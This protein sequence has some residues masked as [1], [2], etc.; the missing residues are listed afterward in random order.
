MLCHA[1]DTQR[2]LYSEVYQVNLY[3]FILSPYHLEHHRILKIDKHAIIVT[4]PPRG[5]VWSCAKIIDTPLLAF[6]LVALS[7]IVTVIGFWMIHPPS[8][9]DEHWISLCVFLD[10]D[11]VELFYHSHTIW[12]CTMSSTV[13]N[14]MLRQSM[15]FAF[16]SGP[17]VECMYFSLT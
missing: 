14:L 3:S 13:L 15:Y 4:G 16:G 9:V 5:T 12:N 8:I 2:N 1:D 11:V 6:S 17:H 7:H 10:D